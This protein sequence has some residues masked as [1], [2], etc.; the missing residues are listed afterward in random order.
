MREEDMK[1]KKYVNMIINTIKSWEY[2][3]KKLSD[4]SK[5]QFLV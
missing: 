3:N 4:F 5:Q 1:R 2:G